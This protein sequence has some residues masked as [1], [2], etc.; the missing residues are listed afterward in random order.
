MILG[1]LI[2]AFILFVHSLSI[3]L[4]LMETL[5]KTHPHLHQ[6]S[7]RETLNK[8]RSPRAKF[9]RLSLCNDNCNTFHLF[10]DPRGQVTQTEYGR[11]EGFEEVSF[12]HRGVYNGFIPVVFMF[13][14]D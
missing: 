4:L 9:H 6:R 11:Q 1:Y 2:I 7:D 13:E 12:E 5:S 14:F 10:L 8:S 3:A